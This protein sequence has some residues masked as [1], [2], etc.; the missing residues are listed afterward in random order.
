MS[1]CYNGQ[2]VNNSNTSENLE[3][4]ES[5]VASI[6]ETSHSTEVK[7]ILPRSSKCKLEVVL[8]RASALGKL[9]GCGGCL[10]FHYTYLI[11]EG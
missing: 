4:A 5:V 1:N 8:C 11:L 9:V 3:A 10:I 6:I 7:H 2:M